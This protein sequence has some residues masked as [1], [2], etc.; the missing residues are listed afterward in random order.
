[1]CSLFIDLL[2]RVSICIIC[3]F[4]KQPVVF[5]SFNRKIGRLFQLFSLSDLKTG[6]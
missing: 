2:K 4:R 5:A 1:M 6:R 3:F